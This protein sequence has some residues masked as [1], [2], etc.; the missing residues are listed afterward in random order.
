MKIAP[1]S[2]ILMIETS[3]RD[4]SVAMGTL[5]GNQFDVECFSPG[6]VHGKEL[7]PRIDALV[8]RNEARGKLSVMAVSTGPGSFTGTRI[9]VSAAKAMAWALKI[10]ALAISSF[11][12]I[13]CNIEDPGR[14]GVLLDASSGDLD[15]AFYE[16]NA[17]GANKDGEERTSHRDHLA[18]LA[19]TGTRFIG[20]GSRIEGLVPTLPTGPV[21]WDHPT[22]QH[23]LRLAIARVHQILDGAPPPAGWDS[24]HSLNP[25]YLRVSRAEEVRRR[26]LAGEEQA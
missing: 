21:E 4:G 9:G 18:E 11:D 3:Q 19:T 25:R 7:Q 13:A 17:D 14:W 2:W 8:E 16:V 1:D 5:D 12:V 22:A 10:P 23:G 26:R 6:L 20:S 15:V 24:P